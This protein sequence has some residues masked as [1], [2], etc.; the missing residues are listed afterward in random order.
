[1]LEV[2]AK[3]SVT[4]RWKA[5]HAAATGTVKNVL[6]HLVVVKEEKLGQQAVPKLDKG[7]WPKPP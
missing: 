6:L 1:M 2:K 7:S 3:S 5:R 4:V